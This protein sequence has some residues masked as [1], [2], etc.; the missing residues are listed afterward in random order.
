MYL[1]YNLDDE[2][3]QKPKREIRLKLLK[4][5]AVLCNIS[6][7]IEPTKFQEL[8]G[9]TIKL[10]PSW[11]S[12]Q[13]PQ[14]FYTLAKRGDVEPKPLQGTALSILRSKGEKAAE[15]QESP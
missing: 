6:R 9:G 10:Q 7:T 13:L 4:D 15:L 3:R 8:L 14:S 11:S 5:E 2:R 1:E 12:K